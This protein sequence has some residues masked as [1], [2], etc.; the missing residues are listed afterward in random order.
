MKTIHLTNEEW[1]LLL[2]MLNEELPKLHH[3]IH[4]TDAR[5]MRDELNTRLRTITRL[6]ERFGEIEAG[7]EPKWAAAAD[8]TRRQ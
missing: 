4:H 3:E 1:A 6:A 8:S 7:A 5:A 2:E